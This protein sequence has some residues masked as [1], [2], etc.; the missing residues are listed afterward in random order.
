[1]VLLQE[2]GIVHLLHYRPFIIKNK[3]IQYKYF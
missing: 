1:L 2:L 3:K